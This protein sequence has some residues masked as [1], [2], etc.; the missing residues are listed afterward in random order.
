LDISTWDLACQFN[1]TDHHTELNGTDRLIVRRG[2]A[3]TINLYLNSGS[4]QPGY[5][6]LHITAET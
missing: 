2:Q 6:Q 1:N 5:T 4:Y 3:F